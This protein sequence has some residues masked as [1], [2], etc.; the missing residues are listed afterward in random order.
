M[1]YKCLAFFI[2]FTNI[3]PNKLHV[4]NTVYY[5]H[6]LAMPTF[7]FHK[8]NIMYVLISLVLCTVLVLPATMAGE[9]I[10][11]AWPLTLHRTLWD[12]DSAREQRT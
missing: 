3:L 1:F 6:P 2:L 4:P 10:S 12:S 5:T 9:V 8:C 11:S 7:G